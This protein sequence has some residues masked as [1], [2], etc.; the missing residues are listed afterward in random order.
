MKPHRCSP[1][2]LGCNGA[3]PVL[4]RTPLVLQWSFADAVGA[5]L[6]LLSCRRGLQWSF[7]GVVGAALQ[8][9]LTDG[10]CN[11]AS[12]APVGLAAEGCNGA[13]P[14]RRVRGCNGASLRVAKM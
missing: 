6:Q 3:P 11:G 9:C 5:A 8:L 4:H 7:A 10:G 2:S 14:R 1:G 12:P 13:S